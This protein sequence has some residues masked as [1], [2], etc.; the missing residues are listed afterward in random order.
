[1]EPIAAHDDA[2]LPE[3]ALQEFGAI[4]RKAIEREF[5][6]AS[7]PEIIFEAPRRP[8]FGDFATNVA[9]FLGREAKRSPQETAS[10]LL[11]RAFSESP[12]VR[13][14]FAQAQALGGFINLRLAPACWQAN[15]A[16]IL[17]ER[18]RFGIAAPNG[19]R[20]SLEFGS[21]NPTGPLVVVQGRTMSIGQTLT[22]AMRSRG[23]SVGT[24]WIINDVGAQMDLLGR[25]LYAR[26]RQLKEPAYP[27][28]EDGYPGEYLIA[29][30]QRIFEAEGDRW[31][32]CAQAE[33]LPHFSLAGRDAI[34][35]EHQAVASRFRVHFDR[36]QSERELHE[37]GRVLAD[38]Q[39]LT[40]R[41]FTY[42]EDGALYFRAT[43]FGDDKDRVLVRSDG[44]PT[45][46]APDI[47]YHYEKLQRSDRVIDI[48]GPD[49]HGYIGRLKG[50]ADALGFPGA[51][52]VIIAQQ[53]T[54]A[55]GTESL[56]IS[57]RAGTIVSLSEILDEV[58][59]DAARF[60]FIML[61]P[62]SPLKFDLALAKERSENN[63]VYYV[64]YS[65]ARISSVFKNAR[66]DEI[67]EAAAGASLDR[68]TEPA[69]LALIRRLCDL[70]R[71]VTNV[72]DQF[73]PHR[74]TQYARDVASDFHQFYAECRILVD[75]R[76]LR[77]ARLGLCL[78]A[79]TVLAHV[80]ELIGV[81]S[82]ESM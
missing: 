23:Y 15:L 28:P 71:L 52:E 35:A 37:S 55:R 59:V 47:A 18:E 49:H 70:P 24:E 7:A 34:V 68:L 19:I 60:F 69:E 67:D 50:V 79:R 62:D 14:L 38:L 31:V 27:L 73:A 36:W 43:L 21:A 44:R 77:L 29:I 76:E 20:V 6:S 11:E 65:H 17:H 58:G 40:D 30:A 22:N 8:E 41:G 16:L 5:P 32:A 45:Y 13:S 61:A 81:T 51:L 4:L 72:I 64:Q 80:L 3:I 75:D 54:L 12:R 33:W 48:L 10:R 56:S 74:L 26:Y 2:P 78:A 9:F 63:P 82:P 53:I 57:K 46:Y 66:R 25:S 1:M 39:R 42:Q